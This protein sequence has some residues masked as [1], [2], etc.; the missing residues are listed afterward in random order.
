MITDAAADAPE[1]KALVYVNAF[2][3][4]QGEGLVNLDTGSC[5]GRNPTDLFDLV[6]YLRGPRARSTLT[7]KQ[8]VVPRCFATG[9]PAP[10]ARV[11]AAAQRPLAA[12]TL[13]EP[14]GPPAWKN[15]P[16]WPW[17]GPAIR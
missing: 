3:P 16:S 15:L 7:F 1:V 11:I 2:I 14:S 6:P 10:Q 13:S 5:L 4:D 9:L 8:N 12:S 17:S